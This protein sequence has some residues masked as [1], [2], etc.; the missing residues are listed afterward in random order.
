LISY[1]GN[2]ATANKGKGPFQANPNRPSLQK[3]NSCKPASATNQG[4]SKLAESKR[5]LADLNIDLV[6]REI[7]MREER[8]K[9]EML[10][11]DE[12]LEGQRLKNKLLRQQ[13]REETDV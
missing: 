1:A 11:I 7:E 10:L 8:H 5:T 3:F 2:S 6:T 12:K 9:K 13:I 4:F